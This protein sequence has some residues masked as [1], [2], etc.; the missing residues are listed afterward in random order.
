MDRLLTQHA[1]RQL[2]LTTYEGTFDQ[3]HEHTPSEV[4]DRAC[5]DKD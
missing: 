5:Y 4:S 3:T 2:T 1:E